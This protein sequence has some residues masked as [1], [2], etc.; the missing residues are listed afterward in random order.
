MEFSKNLI[1]NETLKTLKI[2]PSKFQSY[3]IQ[4]FEGSIEMS[5]M[6]K[7]NKGLTHLDMNINDVSSFQDILL[8]NRN[9]NYL[10]DFSVRSS[11]TFRNDNV[12]KI[13]DAM[14]LNNS[15]FSIKFTC[16]TL[17]SLIFL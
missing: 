13:L 12:Q 14:R 6:L 17:K 16:K 15:I 11:L 7:F 8:E 1:G 2:V 9:L 3:S 10:N 4:S 5:E